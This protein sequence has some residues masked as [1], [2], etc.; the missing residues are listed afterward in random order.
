MKIILNFFECKCTFPRKV[1]VNASNSPS[2]AHQADTH[3]ADTQSHR[4]VQG[5]QKNICHMS[6]TCKVSVKYI[7]EST[8]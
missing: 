6:C 7:Q 4:V 8:K 1:P 2:D 3:Q 5:A